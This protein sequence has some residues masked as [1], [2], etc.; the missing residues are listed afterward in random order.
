VALLW[1]NLILSSRVARSGV[2][3]RV[4]P[5]S[6]LLAFMVSQTA[7][8][9]ADAFA[10][11]AALA[12]V[13][14]TLIGPQLLRND[15][16][17]DLAQI[18]TLKQWPIKGAAIVRG[19]VLAPTMV[20]SAIVWVLVTVALILSTR[21]TF[22]LHLDLTGRISWAAAVML[23][24]PAVMLVQVVA[25][26]ALAILF[27]A[28]MDLGAASARGMEVMGQRVLAAGALI[29]AVG[30]SLLPAFVAA[31]IAGWAIYQLTSARTV[32]LPAA[33]AMFTLVLES[34]LVVAALG[35]VVDRMDASAVPPSE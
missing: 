29:V 28:W 8:T 3:W 31:E 33:V 22:D 34:L 19:E 27:P 15:L 13:G 6:V 25:Q 9:V 21:V 12:A 26:N 14:V 24:A 35:R 11:I 20:L 7:R 5:L 4:L 2:F 18:A 23:V 16:R 1:K 30:L 10:T 32:V 17:Q